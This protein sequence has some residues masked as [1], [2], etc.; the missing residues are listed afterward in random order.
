MMKVLYGLA[1]QLRESKV[2]RQPLHTKLCLPR[3][4]PMHMPPSAVLIL[5]DGGL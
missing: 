1:M 4:L 3:Q 2:P 5:F